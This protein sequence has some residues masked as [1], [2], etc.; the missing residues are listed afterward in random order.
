MKKIIFKSF[1]VVAILVFFVGCFSPKSAISTIVGVDY[2][3]KKNATQYMVFPYGN[4]FIPGKWKETRYFNHSR[5][6]YF[7]NENGNEISISFGPI[8]KIEFNQDGSKKGFDFLKAYFEWEK[9]YFTNRVKVDVKLIEENPNDNYLIFQIYKKED[10]RVKV[11][12]YF[13]I[14]EK[15]N[16]FYNFSAQVLKDWN[17]EQAINFLKEIEFN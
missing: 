7:E 5:Q 14:T 8:N 10:G 4:V 17:Q 9:E 3:E 13:F 12:N 15:H 2:I 1:V 6:Q 11:N 16:T